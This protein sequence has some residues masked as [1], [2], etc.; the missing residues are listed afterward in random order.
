MNTQSSRKTAGTGAKPSARPLLTVDGLAKKARQQPGD[1]RTTRTP[2]EVE[3]AEHQ[4]SVAIAAYYRA[5]QR[6]FQAGHDLEDW[7]AAEAQIA[8]LEAFS[9]P[10]A[11][12]AA[13]T[14]SKS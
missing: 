5:E 7:L 6:G 13:Q 1:T 3:N 8:G 2:I 9:Q 12:G 14:G 11:T 10:A 4:A